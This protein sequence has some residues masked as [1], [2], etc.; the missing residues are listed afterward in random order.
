MINSIDD[1]FVG[2]GIRRQVRITIEPSLNCMIIKCTGIPHERISWTFMTEITDKIREI[3]NHDKSSYYPAGC[4]RFCGSGGR[5][6]EA[7]G[8]LAP[9]GT[10]DS[11][12]SWPSIV[13]EVGDSQRIRA[14]HECAVWWL[15]ES[16]GQTRMVILIKLTRDPLQ[17]HLELWEMIPDPSKPSTQSREP[18]IP[19][20]E[21]YFDIDAEGK[22]THHK[23]HPSLTIP[24]RTIFDVDHDDATDITLSHA[25]MKSWA[26]RLFTG[27]S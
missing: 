7:D 11:Q 25:D 23:D 9:A 22:I 18:K 8:G 13:L 17:L 19:G 26:L 4:S 20:F 15:T 14:L 5:G 2:Y 27:L 24:Y 21:K 10:R 1:A 16:K 12:D 3:P 6:K